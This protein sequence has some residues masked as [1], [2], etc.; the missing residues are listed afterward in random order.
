[1]DM[2]AMPKLQ[3]LASCSLDH[4]IILW[5]TN[6]RTKQKVYEE[7]TR[8]VVSLAFNES[9]I[10]LVSAGIDHKILVWNPYIR[11]KISIIAA[12]LN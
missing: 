1:M 8:G 5:E 7:H 12:S 4:K 11:N 9:L 3:L 10:L 6:G 2:I